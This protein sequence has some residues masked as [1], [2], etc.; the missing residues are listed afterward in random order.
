M[1]FKHV[2]I[3]NVGRIAAF[4]A[5]LARGSVGIV[6]PNGC[7]KSTF[8]DLLYAAVTGDFGRYPGLKADMP[9][10]TADP[11]AESYVRAVVEHAGVVIDVTRNLRPTKARPATVLLVDGQQVTTDA[12]KAKDEIAGV[13]GLDLKL[14]DLYAFK[15]QH[16]I[17][18]FVTATAADRARSYQVL[19]RTQECEEAWAVIGEY[20]NKDR[21]ATTTFVDNSDELTQR[22]GE[23]RSRLDELK[24]LAADAVDRT[25]DDKFL[26]Q[27]EDRVQTARRLEGLRAAE[28]AAA[29]AA[30]L[31]QETAFEAAAAAETAAAAAAGLRAK[32]DKRA[33]EATDARAALKAFGAYRTY[34]ARRKA[35]KD[36]ADALAVEGKRTPPVPPP[37]AGKL[38]EYSRE[39]VRLEQQLERAKEVT[40]AFK[41]TGLAECPTCKTPVS[42]LKAYIDACREAR[43]ALPKQIR[44]LDDRVAAIDAYNADA[45]K[46]GKWRAGYD[47]RVTANA[48]A[49]AALAAVVAPDGDEAELADW[50]KKFEGLERDLAEADRLAARTAADLVRA[51]ADRDA[52]QA[53]LAEASAAAAAAVVDPAK[54]E[55]A[56]R[57]L[58][59]HAAALAEAAGYDG[60]ARGVRRALAQVEADLKALRAKARRAKKVRAMLGVASRVRDAL[61][62]DRLPRRVAATNLARMEGTINEN[63]GL[64]GDPFFVEAAAD[65]S[66]VVHKPGEPPQPATRL[67]TGQRVVLAMAFWP[68]VASLWAAE[69]GILALDEPT[70]NLDA[71]NRKFLSAAIGVMTAKVRGNRQLL[72]VT[73]DAD[74]RTAFDQVVDLGG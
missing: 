34:R 15:Q 54:L 53:R 35:L 24:T 4:E 5:D 13:L 48:A 6:G 14:L 40:K 19:C 30:G 22:A 25:C 63:L 12:N 39:S 51:E 43:D 1:Y 27:Y 74:L 62:R 17:Y 28:K 41:D 64:F 26:R 56:Q 38:A 65:L 20:L 45:A 57:R 10:S 36:E 69:L 9:R 55:K 66:F 3:R 29:A 67:S 60:E 33:A 73:H 23:L 72:M 37:D 42:H 47:A 8:L 58:A 52:K 18:D 11:K 70:A 21:E 61:H 2:E 7:G 46:Y 44:E 59:E 71:E 31:A 49:R 16:A 50:L 68:A 32:R